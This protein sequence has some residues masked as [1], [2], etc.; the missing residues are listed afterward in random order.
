MY[1]IAIKGHLA[2]A[3]YL[4]GYEGPCK[5][6]HGHTWMVEVVIAGERLDNVGMVADFAVL[7]SKLR[8]FLSALDHVCLNDLA[9]FKKVNPT[10]ENIARYIYQNF[11][12]VISPLKIRKVQ[13]WESDSASVVYYE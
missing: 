12:N 10:T 8:D 3:H 9:Y 2:S 4:P 7:K 1:E 5:N 6:L 13:V 11:A